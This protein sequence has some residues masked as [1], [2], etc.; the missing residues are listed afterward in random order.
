VLPEDIKHDE[1]KENVNPYS[2][3]LSPEFWKA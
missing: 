1:K 2:K 3:C